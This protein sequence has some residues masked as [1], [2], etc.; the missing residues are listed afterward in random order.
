MENN[1]FKFDNF[2]PILTVIAKSEEEIVRKI[3]D[4]NHKN[5]IYEIRVDA[6]LHYKNTL[7]EVIYIVNNII[8]IFDDYRFI[9]TIRTKDEGGFI[10][11]DHKEY[12][13][14]WWE[15]FNKTSPQFMDI[16][17]EIFK[18]D[19]RA[20]LNLSKLVDY[21]KTKVISSYHNFKNNFNINETSALILDM[22]ENY[23]DIIKIAININDKH[24]LFM[25]MNFT[26]LISDKLKNHNKEAI[27]IAMGEMGKLTRVWPEYTNSNYMFYSLDK[28]YNTKDTKN[29]KNNTGQ[30]TVFELKKLR[31]KIGLKN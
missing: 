6:L 3:V 20:L 26:H 13:D 14:I 16:K 11:L 15:L 19:E 28:D 31:E 17:Y 9:L 24:D 23:G 7:Q 25:F 1:I 12:F 5:F 30:I 29:T 10:K 22:I 18:K 8:S 21:N 4:N 2:T 27:F